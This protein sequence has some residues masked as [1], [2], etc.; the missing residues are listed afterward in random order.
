MTPNAN[1]QRVSTPLDLTGFAEWLVERGLQGLP[2]DEQVDGFC[3]RVVDSGFPA[4]RFNMS[5][6]TLHPRHGARSYVWR[7]G[8]FVTEEYPRQRRG[9]ELEPYLRSPIFHLRSSGEVKLRRR[10][11][12]GVPH[13]FPVLAELREAGMTDYAAQLVRFGIREP[14]ELRAATIIAGIGQPNLLEGIFFSCATDAPE[15]FNDDHLRQVSDMLPY[16]ALAV[17]SRSTF[18]VARTLLETYLGA[19]AGRRVLTGEIDRHSVQRIQAVIWLC[20]LRGFSG[21]ASRVQ[22]EELV[23]ILDAYLEV[24]ASPVLD[25]R[26]QILKFLGDGFL[27]TFDLS[28]RDR[29][30]ACI[31]A[32]KAAEQLLETVPRFN[33]ERRAAGKRT[34]DFGVAIHL[35]EVLYGNIGSSERLDFTVVGSA[36]NEASRIEGLC[37]PLQRKVLVSSAFQE[38]A[39]SSGGRMVSVGVHALRGIR[40]PQE[41]FTI[42]DA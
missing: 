39:V 20:D 18:D 10:L 36:V 25:N 32:V 30:T 5:I 41:L 26:G 38:A 21:V 4:R 15:G 2:L 27:A 22:Q 12:T 17:K 33:A 13:E 40:E 11:D 16:L 14:Q 29:Q 6:G 24:M 8:G 9:E 31:D 42:A 7:P 34:L 19:D 1:A 28:L 37:R 23:E 3:R 35:G